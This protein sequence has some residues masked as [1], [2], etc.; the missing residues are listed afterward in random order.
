MKRIAV[1]AGGYS[2]ESVVSVKSAQTIIKHLD[3]IKYIAN[4]VLIN[5]QEWVAIDGDT[6]YK[7]DKNDFSFS[8][9]NA[10][11][12]FD[13]V[14]NII[15]G[16]PGEDG[17]IC[18]YFD[19]L[20]IKHTSNKTLQGS[21]T[22]DKYLCNHLAA[23]FGAKIA[24]SLL[25]HKNETIP[26]EKIENEIKFPCFIKPND[27]GSSFGV[28]K[29]QRKEEVSKAISHAFEHGSAVVIEGF[30]NGVEVACGIVS[31]KNTITVFP[32]TEIVPDSEF[33]DYKAKYEGKSKEITP[34]R[35]SS[36]VLNEIQSMTKL[37]FEKF[38]LRGFARIDYIIMNEKPY[39]IEMNTIPG[40]S[41]QSIVPQ[42]VQCHGWSLK[43]FVSGIADEMF[44]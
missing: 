3:P 40:M 9:E 34:A 7:I 23:S 13:G 43:D 8:T 11:I 42:Q 27:S 26:Y 21:L 16:T 15:H 6:A 36:E 5:L 4:L 17:L 41:E 31:L 20:G 2:S 1:I 25:L 22:F 24:P 44:L 12:K 35:I 28:T 37:L 32:V 29:V 30:V 14:F 33:F 19:M 39:L 38:M 10:K 18:G